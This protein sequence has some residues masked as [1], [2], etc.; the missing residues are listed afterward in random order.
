VELDLARIALATTAAAADLAREAAASLP[1]YPFQRRRHW[2]AS[3]QSDH[4]LLVHAVSRPSPDPLYSLCCS[5]SSQ[6]WLCDH[7]VFGSVVF[8][9]VGFIEIILSAS[10]QFA[11]HIFGLT[12]TVF[13]SSIEASAPLI[14][15][16]RNLSSRSVS[17]FARL[18]AVSVP[19]LRSLQL[20]V[21]S[22]DSRGNWTSHVEASCDFAQDTAAPRFLQPEE[23]ITSSRLSSVGPD[24]LYS[25]LSDIGLSYGP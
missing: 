19:A 25:R 14:F 13:I 9:F 10:R 24:I 4:P 11:Q 20:S 5:L 2:V 21:S 16:D 8:P 23:R 12:G 1:T 22:C 17:V 18:G 6:F 3:S 7:V 15:S